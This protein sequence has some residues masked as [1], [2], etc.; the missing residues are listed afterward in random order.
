MY[1]TCVLFLLCI[2]DYTLHWY[3]FT[4]ASSAYLKKH[5]TP[6]HPADLEK[7]HCIDH[8]DNFR[9]TWT[10]T[11]NKKQTDIFVKGQVTVNSSMD[12]KNLAVSGLGLVYL[13]D[14]T[15]IPDIQAGRLKEV[16]MP[17]R[18]EKLA[19]YAVYPSKNISKKTA[20]ILDYLSGL[21][22]A[23]LL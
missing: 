22:T 15:V 19:M 1:S 17:Y 9:N 11:I 3:K 2:N 6:K 5:G 13:P 20:A 12:L 23:S 14:F 21:L 16:L 7:H 4:C 10:Y 18:P 8:Y